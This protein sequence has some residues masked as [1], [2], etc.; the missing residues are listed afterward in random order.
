MIRA[1]NPGV[2]GIAS[3]STIWAVMAAARAGAADASCAARGFLPAVSRAVGGS[4]HAT[5]FAIGYAVT[6]PAFFVA[7]VVPRNNAIVYGLTDGGRA[8]LDLARSATQREPALVPAL[9]VVTA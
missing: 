8:G 6:F 9:A 5:G 1:S 2:E 3:M 4:V 7:R